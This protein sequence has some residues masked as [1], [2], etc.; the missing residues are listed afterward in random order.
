MSCVSAYVSLTAI[1]NGYSS[2]H[3]VETALVPSSG[4]VMRVVSAVTLID[5]EPFT[6]IAASAAGWPSME[7]WNLIFAVPSVWTSA[8]SAKT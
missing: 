1:V 6:E 5:F 4:A 3:V 7:D 8:L 2:L